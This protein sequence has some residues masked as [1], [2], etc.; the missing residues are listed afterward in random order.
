MLLLKPVK[1]TVLMKIFYRK[2]LF[3]LNKA[4]RKLPSLVPFNKGEKKNHSSSN[5]EIVILAL[6]KI[7]ISQKTLVSRICGFCILRV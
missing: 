2:F 4:F 6:G 3:L 1:K 5:S 7:P